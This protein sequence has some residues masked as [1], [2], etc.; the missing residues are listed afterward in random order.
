MFIFGQKFFFECFP[1]VVYLISLSSFNEIYCPRMLHEGD[2]LQPKFC[3]NSRDTEMTLPYWYFNK[4]YS[5]LAF[6]PDYHRDHIIHSGTLLVFLNVRVP[7][8]IM[9]YLT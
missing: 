3:V 1:M 6:G 7:Y 5:Y 2:V 9:W 4:R 8:Y